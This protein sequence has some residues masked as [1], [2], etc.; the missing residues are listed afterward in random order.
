MDLQ[1]DGRHPL[2]DVSNDLSPDKGAIFPDQVRLSPYASLQFL[3]DLPPAP[4]ADSVSRP[5]LDINS[6]PV[7]IQPVDIQE[8]LN[9]MGGNETFQTSQERG[10]PCLNAIETVDIGIP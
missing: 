1:L 5:D 6:L 7:L 4:Q 2:H 3:Q 10:F 8:Q 9:I